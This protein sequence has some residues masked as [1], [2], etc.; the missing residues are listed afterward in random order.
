MA[1]DCKSVFNGLSKTDRLQLRG[2]ALT[3]TITGLIR[4][5]TQAQPWRYPFY[6]CYFVVVTTP[7]PFPSAATMLVMATAV[8]AKRGMTPLARELN[9]RIKDSFNHAALVCAHKEFLEPHPEK[10]DI[11]RVKSLGLAWDTTKQSA[12]HSWDATKHA[13]GAV[14]KFV[15]G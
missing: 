4:D 1:Y 3:K 7:L 8:W 10:T 2:A 15:I 6:A 13:W 12:I 5:D 11:H 14:K 9:R